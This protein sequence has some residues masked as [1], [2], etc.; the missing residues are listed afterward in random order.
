MRTWRNDPSAGNSSLT[1]SRRRGIQVSPPQYGY[2]DLHG[3]VLK[4]GMF[5]P[6][7]PDNTQHGLVI[8]MLFL[9]QK[10]RHWPL[11]VGTCQETISNLENSRAP[12]NSSRRYLSAHLS[13]IRC[14]LHA[15]DI[16]NAKHTVTGP[17]CENTNWVSWK[18]LD[19]KRM[20]IIRVYIVIYWWVF[21]PPSIS[22]MPAPPRN[23]F[24][25]RP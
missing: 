25:P 22:R 12:G 11:H 14:Y 1:G 15:Q 17:S 24:N 20:K 21:N 4:T 8:A 16:K 19:S 23:S 10:F 3:T 18:G 9:L 5:S 7:L 2:N 6:R 13:D